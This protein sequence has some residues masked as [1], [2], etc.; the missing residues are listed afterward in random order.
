MEL[1]FPTAWDKMRLID[2]KPVHQ[3]FDLKD[4]K[5]IASGEPGEEVCYCTAS[6]SAART[7][8]RC[9][10]FP[11]SRVDTAGAGTDDRVVQEFEEVAAALYPEGVVSPQPGVNTRQQAPTLG[12]TP[13]TLT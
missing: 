5:L 11:T 8:G 13:A 4:A 6:A 1:G 12:A 9:R 3:T 7:P 10:R 2:A